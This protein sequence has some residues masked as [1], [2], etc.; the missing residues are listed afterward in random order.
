MSALTDT[1]NSQN[2]SIRTA[3]LNRTLGTASR[4]VKVTIEDKRAAACRSRIEDFKV[5]RE[6][7][8]SLNE[9]GAV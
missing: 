4:P 2:F 3:F 5:A 7:G 9:L 6:L 1:I 8:V